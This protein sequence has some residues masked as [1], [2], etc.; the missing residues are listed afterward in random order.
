MAGLHQDVLGLQVAMDHA[1]RM[2]VP[3]RARDTARDANHIVDGELMFAVELRAQRLSLHERHD[4]EQESVG[5][6]AVE[7]GKEVRVLQMRGYAD[8]AEKSLDAEHR[9]QFGL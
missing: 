9:A 6:A 2:R 3:Q 1:V 8:L 5:L 4:I 7:Q